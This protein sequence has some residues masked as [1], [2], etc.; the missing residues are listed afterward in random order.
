M[1]SIVILGTGGGLDL[2]DIVEGVNRNNPSWVVVGF[3]DDFQQAA[4]LV[5]SQPVLGRLQDASRYAGSLSINAIG[6]DQSFRNRPG[7]IAGTGIAAESFAT[8]IHPFA[9]VSSRCRIG[10]GVSI[11]PGVTI[12]GGAD[13]GDHVTV[14]P[15]AIVGHESMIGNYSII[16]PGAIVSGGVRIDRTSYIGAGPCPAAIANR[17]GN[18]GGHGGGGRSRRAPR[19]N[20]RRQSREAL[21]ATSQI[22]TLSGVLNHEHYRRDYPLL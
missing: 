1:Q 18:A 4:K 13:V 16:A 8:L 2:L 19:H 10:R 12:G 20:G 5:W 11:G 6:S 15:G 14:C 3:L 17:R 21:L 9:S 7:I 22:E